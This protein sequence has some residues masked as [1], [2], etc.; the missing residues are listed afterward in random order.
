MNERE[1]VLRSLNAL[2]DLA[3]QMLNLMETREPF[4]APKSPAAIELASSPHGRHLLDAYSSG[5]QS[6]F[7]AFDH[8]VALGRSMTEPILTHSPWTCARAVLENCSVAGWLLEPGI[9]HSDRIMRSFNL[10]YQNIQSNLTFLRNEHATQHSDFAYLQSRIEDLRV[11]ASSLGFT[12]KTNK[13]SKC[14]GFGP[15]LPS[16]TELIK[17]FIADWPVPCLGY[18][19]LS[20][21]AHGEDWAISS[22]GMTTVSDELGAKRVPTMSPDSA[23][24]L[25][26]DT[27]CWTARPAWEYFRLFG[28]DLVEIQ[29]V[30]DGVYD[31][32]KINENLKFWKHL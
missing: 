2:N 31:Q 13:K 17:D 27:V 10:K 18:S 15:G 20:A 25:I 24:V 5:F 11:E 12:E 3:S 6:W 7:V 29:D 28:W 32:V 9:E 14:L 1:R 4:P 23:T 19:L 26:A 8:M 21:A 16:H 30:L 22:L